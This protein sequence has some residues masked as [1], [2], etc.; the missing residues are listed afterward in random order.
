VALMLPGCTVYTVSKCA[1]T[2]VWF[3]V[4]GEPTGPTTDNIFIRP[5][6]DAEVRPKAKAAA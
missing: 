6:A 5:L 1:F 2:L 3:A 4:Q